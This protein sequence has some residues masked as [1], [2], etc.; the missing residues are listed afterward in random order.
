MSIESIDLEIKYT[1]QFIH[2][3]NLIIKL[4]KIIE[5]LA[6]NQTNEIQE[7]IVKIFEEK[8][9]ANAI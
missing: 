2:I 8:T 4:V 6:E 5:I 1:K 7:K 3:N 9:N